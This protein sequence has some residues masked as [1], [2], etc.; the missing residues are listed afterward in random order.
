MSTVLS[1]T[2]DDQLFAVAQN[3]LLGLNSDAQLRSF[4]LNQ[5]V[6]A[7]DFDNAAHA[8]ALQQAL[9][10]DQK[11][12]QAF[13]IMEIPTLIVTDGKTFYYLSNTTVANADP[14]TFI[15]TLASLTAKRPE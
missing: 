11:L 6:K 8:S 15:A 13:K 2:F 1:K 4:F 12:M 10:N 5:G 14:N 7:A 9:Q 3:P